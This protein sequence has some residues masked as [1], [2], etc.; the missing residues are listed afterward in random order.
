MGLAGP[1]KIGLVEARPV[2]VI[3]HFLLH[4][5]QD[6]LKR[7]GVHQLLVAHRDRGKV[8]VVALVHLRNLGRVQ[9]RG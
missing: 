5:P 1:A 8:R 9:F 6:L 3:R 7:V 2:I 4:R